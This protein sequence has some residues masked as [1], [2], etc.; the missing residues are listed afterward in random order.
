[1]IKN[2]GELIVFDVIAPNVASLTDELLKRK[3]YIAKARPIEAYGGD[4]QA[5]MA[6]NNTSAFNGRA[7]TGGS[8][9]SLHAYGAALDLNP[10]QNPYIDIS[11]DGKTQIS[12]PGSAHYSVNRS[13]NRPNKAKRPGMAEDVVDLFARHGFFVW[14]GDWNY[15]ID[16]QHF[17]IGPRSFVEALS[18]TSVED[19]RMLIDRYISMYTECVSAGENDDH[20]DRLRAECVERVLEAMCR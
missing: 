9:W 12:P 16:Y 15:P 7:I 20:R 4:D 1:V 11:E 6:D 13:E 3:F 18:E 8:A 2:D 19:G 10:L 14:G 5:S 17:Q